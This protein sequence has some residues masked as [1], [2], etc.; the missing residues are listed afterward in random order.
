MT[1]RETRALQALLTQPT[2][3]AAAAAAGIGESTLRTYLAKPE[4]Q[5]AYNEALSG[6]IS[7][8]TIQAKQ[9]LAPALSVL[10]EIMENGGEAA[11]QRVQA[12]RVSIDCALKLTTVYEQEKKLEELERLVNQMTD[13]KF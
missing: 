12:A 3:K 6:L 11:A 9:S 2:K 8:A 4:F 7:D 10:R 13:R 1:Q 5:A